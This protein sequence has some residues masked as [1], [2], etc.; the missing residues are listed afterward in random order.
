[1]SLQ[2]PG[3]LGKGGEPVGVDDS[4]DHQEPD[5]QHQT[6]AAGDQQRLTR[7]AAGMFVLV[8]EADEQIRQQRGQLPEDEQG[9]QVVGQHQSE[10]G[11]QKQMQ[12]GEKPGVMT[13]TGHVVG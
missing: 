5:Q 13:V 3:L 1:M 9:D 11:E 2:E 7:M 10:H 8:V 4:A 6:T 12:K